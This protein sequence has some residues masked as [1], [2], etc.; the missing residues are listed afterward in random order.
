MEINNCSRV[1]T[2]TG[3]LTVQALSIANVTLSCTED[4][5]CF[6][7]LFRGEARGRGDLDAEFLEGEVFGG[8]QSAAEGNQT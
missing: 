6:A 7:G 3:S 2:V 1:S 8:W 5:A 4:G